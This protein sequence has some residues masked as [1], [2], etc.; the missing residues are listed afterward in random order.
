MRTKDLIAKRERRDRARMRE[1]RNIEQQVYES[2]SKE[3]FVLPCDFPDKV[4]AFVKKC[5]P[6][7]PMRKSCVV[8]ICAIH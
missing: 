5:Q 6:T 3:S 7:F 4:L 8:A 1:Q 2:P